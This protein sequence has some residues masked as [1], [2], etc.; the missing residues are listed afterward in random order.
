MSRSD[1]PVRTNWPF[2]VF[3]SF[4]ARSADCSWGLFVLSSLHMDFP[5][6]ASDLLSLLDRLPYL[7]KLKIIEPVYTRHSHTERLISDELLYGLCI[8]TETGPFRE[9]PRPLD[10]STSF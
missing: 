10:F 7:T 4:A 6:T 2:S 8:G 3:D 9:K 1:G 5:I